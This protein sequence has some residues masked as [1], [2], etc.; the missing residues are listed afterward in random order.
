VKQVIIKKG[1]RGAYLHDGTAGE[2]IPG[3]HVEVLDTTAAGDAFNGALEV[4]LEKEK[5]LG[6]SVRFANAAGALSATKRGAQ[7][8]M[9]TL[10]EVEKFLN[11]RIE[12]A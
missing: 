5:T 3:F 7:P 9:P 10:A 8:S 1:A 4:A 2:K 12:N 6:E 11:I